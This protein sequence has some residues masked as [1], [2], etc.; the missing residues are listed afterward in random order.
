MM[1]SGTVAAIPV[2]AVA[3]PMPPP[4][5]AP[6]APPTAAADPRVTRLCELWP[7]NSCLHLGHCR[8]AMMLVISIGL[9]CVQFSMYQ[10]YGRQDVEGILLRHVPFD[11]R[12]VR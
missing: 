11:L 8:F 6:A 9:R 2:P 3:I 10:R 5:M 7:S 1:P 12:V 4:I